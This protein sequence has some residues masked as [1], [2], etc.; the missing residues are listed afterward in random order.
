MGEVERRAAI[1]NVPQKRIVQPGIFPNGP[2]AHVCQ[3]AA[4]DGHT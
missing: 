3:A 2:N 1:G 4:I